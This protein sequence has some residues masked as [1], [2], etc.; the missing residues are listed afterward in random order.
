MKCYL[1][2]RPSSCLRDLLDYGLV[3][4]VMLFGPLDILF[5]VIF[6]IK[7]DTFQ[8]IKPQ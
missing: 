8:I 5:N 2:A 7:K 3:T 6:K 4:T 1:V